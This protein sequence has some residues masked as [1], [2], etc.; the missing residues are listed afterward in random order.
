MKRG[1]RGAFDLYAKLRGPYHSL[2]LCFHPDP[3]FCSSAAQH[4]A[5]SFLVS[6]VAGVV[7]Y[8]GEND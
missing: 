5:F 6:P 3:A 1:G 7:R 2:S 4:L 8:P